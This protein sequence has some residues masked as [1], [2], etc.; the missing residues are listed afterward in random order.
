[1]MTGENKEQF[2][3]FCIKEYGWSL[4]NG[5]YLAVKEGEYFDELPFEMQIGVYMAYYDSIDFLIT[6]EFDRSYDWFYGV[7]MHDIAVLR[8]IVFKTR[9]VA[10]KSAFKLLDKY[11]N[12]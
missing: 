1:M 11:I 9:N 6:V 10:Y 8:E 12:I 3:K 2:D 5:K 4:Y 7:S